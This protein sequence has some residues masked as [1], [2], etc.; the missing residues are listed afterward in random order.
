LAGQFHEGFL[1]T[2]FWKDRSL[3]RIALQ[4]ISMLL[5]QARDQF[6]ING[7][8]QR[9]TPRNGLQTKDICQLPASQEK[10]PRCNVFRRT[11]SIQR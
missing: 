4:G 10:Q 2:V 8:G 11:T 9:E 6:G 7:F 1:H 3:S 5:K